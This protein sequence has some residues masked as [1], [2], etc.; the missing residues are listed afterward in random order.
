MPTRKYV[1]PDERVGLKLTAAE[2]RLLLDD[3][4]WLDDEYSDAIRQTP[5]SQS[6]E[7]T[8]EQ[9]DDFGGYIA[10]EANHTK[11]RKLEKKLDALFDKVQGLLATHTDEKPP[12]IVKI[13]DA[14][15]A[16]LLTPAGKK[17]KQPQKKTASG[18][19]FQFKITLLGIEPAIWRRIQTKDCTLDKLHEHIQAAMGWTNS[20]L[21]QFIIN[22]VIHGGPQLLDDGWEETPPVNSR[23]TKLSKIMP[24]DG[25]RLSFQYEYD[26]GDGWEH[27]VL[28]EGFPPAEKGVRHPLCV[29]GERA[30]PPEDVGGPHGYQEYVRAMAN[31]RHKQHQEFLEWNGPFDPE[32]FDAQ[33]ATKEMRKGLPDWRNEEEWI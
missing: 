20:H 18:T 8:L 1:K 17:A 31:P 9:W 26:F 29:E 15:K 23:R 3:V 16:N 10:A 14:K 12:K 28:F 22:D 33:A 24:K 25:R 19:V 6:V 2:R 13:K 32:K 4:M 11:D 27:E 30:C 21:H 7:L 5:A